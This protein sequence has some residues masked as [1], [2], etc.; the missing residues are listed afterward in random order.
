MCYFRGCLVTITILL[1]FGIT[2]NSYELSKPTNL[3]EL[4]SYMN[5]GKSKFDISSQ[6]CV[7]FLSY[8]NSGST[9]C[10]QTFILN[11]FATSTSHKY[12][13]DGKFFEAEHNYLK[14]HFPVIITHYQV[15]KIFR[16]QFGPCSTFLLI[17]DLNDLIIARKRYFNQMG[18]KPA[19]VEHIVIQLCVWFGHWLSNLN[20]FDYVFE[21]SQL[22]DSN[23]LAT[24]GL[25]PFEG[26]IPH[27]HEV[28]FEELVQEL[29][30]FIVA[31]YLPTEHSSAA[32]SFNYSEPVVLSSKLK[33]LCKQAEPVFQNIQ[34]SSVDKHMRFPEIEKIELD[35][36]KRLQERGNKL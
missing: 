17:R 23:E 2:C 9:I 30:N 22:F 32:S 14:S 8:P 5:Q 21:Y 3:Q 31:S 7:V 36:E 24:W 15:E 26:Q 25:K 29:I 6:R 27:K 18:T 4:L 1:T 13:T 11:G 20:M 10:Q 35:L 33:R 12:V 19:T 34:T 16:K 28:L